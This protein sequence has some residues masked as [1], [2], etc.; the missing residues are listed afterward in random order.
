MIERLGSGGRAAL[1]AG[2]LLPTFAADTLASG[3]A[4]REQSGS[5]QG[6]S[7]AGVA[8]GGRDISTMYFNP[9]TLGLHDG[10]QV[11]TS[12]SYIIPRSRFKDG[13]GTTPISGAPLTG[14]SGGNIADQA[15]VPATYAMIATGN[16][17]F[18]LGITAPFGL[19]TE[20]PDDWIGRYHATESDLLTVNINPAVA[21]RINDQFTVAAGFVAQ[22]ADATLGNA[23]SFAPG[24]PDAQAEVKGSDWD[25]GFTLGVLAQ[26]TPTTRVGLGYRS[27]INHSL[28]GK[29]RISTE[30][31]IPPQPTVGGRAGI[32]TPQIASLGVAQDLGERWTVLGTVE[33]T[34]WSTFD[35][36][37]ITFDDGSNPSVTEQKWRDTWFFALG[38]EYRPRSDLVLQA[39]VAYDQTP[40]RDAYRTPRIPDADRTWISLGVD[41]QPLQWARVGAGYSRIFVA[42][43]K[44]DLADTQRGNLSGRFENSIDIVTLHGSLRF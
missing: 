28:T 30:A 6:L 2:A 3:Y 22:Y 17:H 27:Q 24:T 34:G 14:S 23:V 40:N 21:Y 7:Y 44:I 10:K 15:I 20:Q 43:G 26:P 39:G 37:R 9:A 5:F 35:E 8:A 11:H 4:I 36:L 38:A 18:G 29:R 41:W 31:P 33:W 19:R 32:Q 12:I 42:D 1:V 25:Y 16:W 13:S